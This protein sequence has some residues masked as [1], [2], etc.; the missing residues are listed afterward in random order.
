[1]SDAIRWMSARK[2]H[3]GMKDGSIGTDDRVGIHVGFNAETA[4]IRAPGGD[5]TRQMLFA[6][7][8][9]AVDRDT[10]TV[11]IDGWD[12]KNYRNN[13]VVLFGHNYWNNEAPVVGNSLS[14]FVA[15]KKLKSLMEFTP[16]GVVPLADTLHALYANGFMHATSVGFIANDYEFVE[17]DPGRPWGIDFLEQELLEYSLVPV[18]SNPEALAE[19]RSKSIDTGPLC[20]WAEQI[21]DEWKAHKSQSFYLP[22]SMLRDIRTQADPK[23]RTTAQVP[24]GEEMHNQ[25]AAMFV[26]ALTPDLAAE[27]VSC[28][29]TNTETEGSFTLPA[30]EYTWIGDKTFEFPDVDGLL[31]GTKVLEPLEFNASKWQIVLDKAAEAE[32]ETK[33]TLLPCPSCGVDIQVMLV[34][35][36]DDKAI[37]CECGF[38]VKHK[39][40]ELL[41]ITSD[42]LDDDGTEPAWLV[43]LRAS[44]APEVAIEAAIRAHE[45]G[46][47]SVRDDDAAGDTVELSDEMASL[48][49]LAGVD[50]DAELAK[51]TDAGNDPDDDS[52]DLEGI[53]V[54]NEDGTRCGLRDFFE[55]E[56]LPESIDEGVKA[57]VEN[58]LPT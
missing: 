48:L 56:I 10:D 16:Q 40:G 53:E 18:P 30:G 44:N 1:M 32:P 23:Q 22:K 7:S 31:V 11:A 15:N 4:V 33:I 13:P 14:E 43:G 12:L 38:K 52:F 25:A 29:I 27:L 49:E 28:S 58:V 47:Q 35:F 26:Q 57:A 20:E 6:I 5:E 17:D 55:Q 19:A 46:E 51:D 2:F 3:E 36:D 34:E 39:N 9:Q 21:L 54:V 37:E 24:K 45:R 50:V 8:S 42:D 41:E